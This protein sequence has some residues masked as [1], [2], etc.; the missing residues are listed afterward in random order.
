MRIFINIVLIFILGLTP[1]L[2]QQ[3]FRQKENRKLIQQFEKE[4]FNN[5]LQLL[6]KSPT[7]NQED[8]DIHFYT[9][10]L[11]LWPVTELL[12]GAVVIE[13]ESLINGLDHIEI[14]LFSNMVIDSIK[15]GV[16]LLSYTHTNDLININLSGAINQG[17]IFSVEVFYSGNPQSGGLGTWGWD[18]TSTGAP[19]IWTL[20][21]PFGSPAWWPCKDDPKDKADSVFLNITVPEDLIVASNGLLVDTTSAGGSRLTFSWETRYPISTYLVSL[22]ISNYEQFSDWYVYSP[23]DSMELKYYVY[24][25]DL[26]DA[27]EDF[28][29]T[30]DMMEFFVTVFDEYPFLNEKYGMS[31]FPWGGA[32]E[33]QT[34]TSYGE[35]LIRGDHFYDYINAHELAH[36]WFGD[37]ITMRRW[38]HIWLNEGFASYSEALW[39]ESIGGS[40]AYH[41]YMESQ[42]PGFF[43][44]SLF[45]VDST[46]SNALFSNTVYDKGSWALH[47]L[48]G[49]LGDSLFFE[50]LHTYATDPGFAYATA[51]TEDLRNLCESVTGQDLHWFFEEWVY[52]PGR[53]NYV[54]N[55]ETVGTSPPYQTTLNLIQAYNEPYK[56]PVQ[57]RLFGNG[58]DTTFTVWDSLD[59]QQFIFSTGIEPLGLQ[60]DPDNWILKN[61][62]EG[63]VYSVE[64]QVIDI[65]DT[66]GVPMRKFIGLVPMI[67]LPEVH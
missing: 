62:I 42:D 55:W 15:Q 64:G 8:F 39:E 45:V 31:E 4:R 20:S 52:R 25:E 23:T 58:L 34:N 12:K 49:V 14:D 35:P 59:T 17:E 51:V 30:D 2:A 3:D 26:A 56:M 5:Q 47:M 19:I 1:L 66:S 32:M 63:D 10:N 21:Q 40:T 36:Q 65:G 9:L 57:I 67:L 24:P 50:C 46:N 28:N 18:S 37:C 60:V 33:H 61:L 22:A 48:R 44:G 6:T 27:Q 53:P 54:F 13:G 7:Q 16:N 41:A 38:S 43:E 29:V 11:G